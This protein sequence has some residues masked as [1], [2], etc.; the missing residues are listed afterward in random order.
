MLENTFQQYTYSYLLAT[1]LDNVPSTVDKRQG[2][3]VYD[4]LAPACYEL[5]KTYMNL[6][7]VI[8]K[9]DVEN[10]EGDELEAFINERTAI[11][12][13]E[14]VAA[15]GTVTFTGTVGT[16][17]PLG[18][19]V[20]SDEANYATTE[21]GIIGVSGTV[22]IAVECEQVGVVGNCDAG[23]INKVVTSLLGVYNVSNTEALTNGYDEEPDSELLTR[24]FDKLQR[25]GK[26]G[27]AYHY[28]EWAKAVPGVGDAKVYPAWNG[29]LTV[30]VVVIDSNS[31]AAD[32][33]L[34]TEVEDAIETER[35]FGATVTVISAV[36]KAINVSA[37]IS[38]LEQ[39][40]RQ[41]LIDTI[42]A[43]IIDYLKE[44]AF[45]TDFVSYAKIGSIIIETEGVTDYSNLLVNTGTANVTLLD[46]EIPVA[47]T[48]SIV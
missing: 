48:M 16:N 39:Y 10:L 33:T 44:I 35:P 27:N 20:G 22:E 18:S 36:E 15:T 34:I 24:Y 2:S 32:P 4:A 12:R 43:S 21:E 14:G 42:T 17:I 23:D 46:D 30:K 7:T 38:I 37:T 41:N 13:K 11:V 28:E 29:P 5:A 45:K 1:A 6:Q 9:W 19:R 31:Q 25:P 47:G 8:N 40:S 3:I 26:A